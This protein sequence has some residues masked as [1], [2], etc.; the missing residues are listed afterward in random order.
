MMKLSRPL[1]MAG[2]AALVLSGCGTAVDGEPVASDTPTSA[3]RTSTPPRTTT[4]TAYIAES[5]HE[6]WDQVRRYWSDV[7]EVDIAHVT[8]EVT[9][10]VIACAGTPAPR[11]N[12]LYC[13]DGAKDTI[14]YNPRAVADTDDARVVE[15]A[16]RVV[17]AHEAG[18][19][20]QDAMDTLAGETGSATAP[21]EQSADCFAGFY[22]ARRDTSTR[23]QID[24][25][26]DLTALGKHQ[27][28]KSAFFNGYSASNAETC[29]TDYGG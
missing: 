20:I 7:Q 12:S 22:M 11:V 26:L 16:Q 13:D 2:I 1:V 21:S 9:T 25:A 28:R 15:R 17:L 3:T 6:T 8:L 10:G 18:H 29:F 14:I 19:A 23:A 24:A 5:P 27:A 4:T